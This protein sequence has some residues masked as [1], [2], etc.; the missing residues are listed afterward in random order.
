M[1][2]PTPAQSL[3]GIDA[4]LRQAA[5][6]ASTE[7]SSEPPDGRSPAPS[8]ASSESEGSQ[9]EDVV[10]IGAKI[11]AKTIKLDKFTGKVPK[12]GFDT[13]ASEWWA[14]FQEEVRAGQILAGQRWSD[15]AKKL[16][17]SS[18]LDELARRWYKR[19]RERLPAATFK[20]TG[21][22]LVHHFRP[23][24]A[25][26][27]LMRKLIDEPRRS[28]ESFRE[29]ADRL[30][31]LAENLEGGISVKANQRA[32]LTTFVR[33]AWPQLA[34][35]YERHHDLNCDDPLDQ[36][37]YFINKL[38]KDVGHDGRNTVKKPHFEASKRRKFDK[39]D[40]PAKEEGKALAII[41]ERKHKPAWKARQGQATGK[42]NGQH[43]CAKCGSPG[44]VADYH[45]RFIDRPPPRSV[46]FKD[47]EQHQA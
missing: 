10:K 23:Q 31:S 37:E 2:P 20:E 12:N 36:L 17:L 46:H 26:Q 27:D 11:D 42:R 22:A 14:D 8:V 3:S 28:H 13:G 38:C 43:R 47:E 32:A 44:H 35:E 15:R 9:D 21:D 24:L 39:R 25:Y 6:A 1:S 40:A 16:L 18:F 29:Y 5:A 41:P 7:S 30:I 45:D 4:F 34:G 19:F 33:R